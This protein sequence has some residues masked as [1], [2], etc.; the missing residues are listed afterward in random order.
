MHIKKVSNSAFLIQKKLYGAGGIRTCDFIQARLTLFAN[1]VRFFSEQT[2]SQIFDV[3]KL[4][5]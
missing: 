4:Q 3:L 5:I 1:F 2:K